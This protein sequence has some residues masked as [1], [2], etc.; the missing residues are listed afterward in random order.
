[1]GFFFFSQYSSAKSCLVLK[2]AVVKQTEILQV[3]DIV[4]YTYNI[5]IHIV[6]YPYKNMLHFACKIFSGYLSISSLNHNAYHIIIFIFNSK[7][8]GK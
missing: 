2:I 8:N 4:T 7:A 1:M 6:T 3:A 5:S